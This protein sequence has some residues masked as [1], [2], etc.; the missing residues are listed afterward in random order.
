MTTKREFIERQL[1]F[2]LPDCY[3]VELWNIYA[4]DNHYEL[5]YPN[6]DEEIDLLFSKPSEVAH[7]IS[8]GTYDYD[9]DYIWVNGHGYLLSFNNLDDGNSPIDWDELINYV[10][11]NLWD[12]DILTRMEH[13]TT[14]K[15]ELTG[16]FLEF[17][18][19]FNITEEA[20]TEKYTGDIESIAIELDW[21]TV[22][23]DFNV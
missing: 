3:V 20:L 2:E 22:V 14:F 8:R 1:R 11:D 9:D 5:I 23:E 4:E 13:N 17:C 16:T 15:D 6:E 12:M 19:S 21:E 7:A 18:E 10:A